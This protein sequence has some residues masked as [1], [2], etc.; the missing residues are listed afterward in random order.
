MRGYAEGVTAPRVRALSFHADYACRH[1]AACCTAPWRI[2]IDAR[3]AADIGAALSHG[4]LRVGSRLVHGW[5]DDSL[6]AGHSTATDL[7][8]LVATTPAGA[9]VFLDQRPANLCAIHRDCGHDALPEA[10]QQFPRVTLADDRGL[11]VTLSH[12]CPTVAAM[13]VGQP[14]SPISIVA[15][16]AGFA[17][18]PLAPGLDARG[19][20]PPLLR[21]GV[22]CSHETWSLWESWVVDQLGNAN[23]APWETVAHASRVADAV[24]AWRAA[25]GSQLEYVAQVLAAAGGVPHTGRLALDPVDEWQRAWNAVPRERASAPRL[26]VD[27]QAWREA[28]EGAV[29]AVSEEGPAVHRYL[30]AR[31]FASW[32]AYQGGGLRTHVSSVRASFGVLLVELARA[33]HEGN[34]ASVE[35]HSRGTDVV[36]EAPL[37]RALR[38]SDWLLVHLAESATLTRQWAAAE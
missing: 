21:P 3:R 12:F 19:E 34:N 28:L 13:T 20:W 22:L 6:D 36:T 8:G 30:A 24:R 26:D 10:C 5:R 1:S 25:D 23:A 9:C 4:Q 27:S 38:R 35:V 2:A 37:L 29:A 7:G 32:C 16:P 11:H 33:S 18:A 14:A 31:A 15:P 17:R